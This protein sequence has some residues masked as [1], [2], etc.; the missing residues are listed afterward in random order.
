VKLSEWA[1]RNGVPYKTA[2]KWFRTGVLPDPA[3]QLKTGTILVR[4]NEVPSEGIVALY[5]RV[6]SHGQKADLERQQGRLVAWATE[7]G[8]KVGKVVAEVGSGPNGRRSKLLALLRDP[9]VL[10]IVVEH[11]DR[12]ARFGS[13]YIEATLRQAGRH[14]LVVEEGEANDD[15]VQDMVDLLTSFCARLDGKRSAKNRA[16]KAM[17]AARA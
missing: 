15:L 14:L 2:W 5:A 8:L 17:E 16:R 13:D 9:K 3:I 10:T 6:S 1:R 4:I 11:R 7:R 12:L